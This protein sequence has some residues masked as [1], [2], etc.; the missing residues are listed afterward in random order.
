MIYNIIIME[1]IF[2]Y[3]LVDTIVDGVRTSKPVIPVIKIYEFKAHNPHHQPRHIVKQYHFF[4]LVGSDYENNM[5]VRRTHEL[6]TKCVMVFI[7][8]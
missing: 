8:W 6:R 4:I 5:S 1:Y 2:D 3:K 7:M